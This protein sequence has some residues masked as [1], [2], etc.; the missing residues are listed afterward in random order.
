MEW[1]NGK[2]RPVLI[3]QPELIFYELEDGLETGK[4]I[5]FS[6]A[7]EYPD[8]SNAALIGPYDRSNSLILGAHT[9]TL[10]VLVFHVRTWYDP[11]SEN[12]DFRFRKD[13][14]YRVELTYLRDSEV[15]RR[16]ATLLD[17][18]PINASVEDLSLYARTASKWDYWYLN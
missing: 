4:E 8:T 5:R 12:H 2:G 3:R 7:G 16:S 18:L 9:A 6:L 13:D 10:D 1:K 17:E 14:K 15:E 11:E